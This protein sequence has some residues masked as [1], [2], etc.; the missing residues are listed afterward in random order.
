VHGLRMIEEAIPAVAIEEVD[1]GEDVVKDEFTSVLPPGKSIILLVEDR[2]DMR[3]YIVS[4]LQGMYHVVEAG[5]AN[6]GF[7]KATELIPDVII[8][9][10]MM[11]GKNGLE[12]C[13]EL[14]ADM[15]TSH[16]P[17]M[18][19]TA[20]SS[21]EDR[22][23]GLETAADVYLTKPFIPQELELHLRNL[24]AS[25]QKI[26]DFYSYHR[27]IEPSKMSFNSMDEKFLETFIGHLETHY[28]KESF[29]V[30]QL[31]DLM[32][33]S[34][35]QVH[36]KLIALTGQA[37]NRLIRTYRLKK[38]YDMV[39]GNAATIGEIAFTVGFGSPAYFTKCFVEEFGTTPGDVRNR[40][41]NA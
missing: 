17:V 18:L 6:E 39:A 3:D 9:D 25:R 30:E 37:P 38:A 5:N 1:N 41:V 29:S 15:R 11:P 14:K 22:I 40:A 35:S 23:S 28:S 20:K 7:A 21:P 27:R 32:N 16:V 8:S 12:L 31:A 36:R 13:R 2:K 19:L 4:V 34:R 33:L 26:K 10:V 24:I